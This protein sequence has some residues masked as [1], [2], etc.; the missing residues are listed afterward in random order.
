MENQE[1]EEDVYS[2]ASSFP[3]PGHTGHFWWVKGTECPL[4]HTLPYSNSVNNCSMGKIH[5]CAYMVICQHSSLVS[6]AI[7]SA[8]LKKVAP[9]KTLKLGARN[10]VLRNLNQY[11]FPKMQAMW[12]NRP[13]ILRMTESPGYKA[14]T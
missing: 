4:P 10:L 7:A 3:V 1:K 5:F 9:D 6:V 2:G 12:E 14:G 13:S 11:E 8:A